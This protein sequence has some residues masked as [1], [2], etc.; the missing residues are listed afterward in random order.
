MSTNPPLSFE[1]FPPQ[2]IDSAGTAQPM[3]FNQNS[4]PMSGTAISGQPQAL[5]LSDASVVNSLR[6]NIMGQHSHAVVG[7]VPSHDPHD[8]HYNES[9]VPTGNGTNQNQ[10]AKI[11]H[12]YI[13][14]Q[15]QQRANLNY[16]PN[17]PFD[18]NSYPLTNP[19]IFDSTYMLPYSNDGIPR[20]RRVS[21][22]NGQIGQIMSHEAFFDDLETSV[23]EEFTSKFNEYQL[24]KPATS[25][26]PLPDNGNNNIGLVHNGQGPLGL[27]QNQVQQPHPHHIQHQ[28]QQQHL[29]H[30]Q[31]S[32]SRAQS[33]QLPDISTS[34]AAAAGGAPIHS[35]V[36]GV[37]PP[38]HQLIYNNE[39]IYNPN[40]GPIVG[41]A[42]WKKERLLQRNRVAASKCRQRKKNAQIQLQD[43]V[44]KMEAD[45]KMKNE[46][47]NKLQSILSQYKM[48]IRRYLETG[49][50]DDKLL[51]DLI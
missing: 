17:V 2:T 27:S 38:N 25:S 43:S 20:R 46:E 3:N 5:N 37:P 9:S 13:Q 16:P 33:Q 29:H 32:L 30:H 39:V 42:A 35:Q 28:Q 23:D 50:R 47:I 8:G 49:E 1:Q 45:L 40:N 11:K 22:S 51:R 26:A 10:D 34:T 48:N 7:L 44:N 41:T 6:S 31:Q 14:E 36:A 21:I 15:Q 12:E 19:P 4:L 24:N 18:L